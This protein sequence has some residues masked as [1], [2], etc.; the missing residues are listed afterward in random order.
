MPSLSPRDLK[1]YV[2]IDIDP[3]GQA[4]SDHFEALHDTA[5]ARRAQFAAEGV[6]LQLWRDARLI[7]AWRRTGPRSFEPEAF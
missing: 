7:G 4:Q 3:D 1:S 5:A 6:L 2:A